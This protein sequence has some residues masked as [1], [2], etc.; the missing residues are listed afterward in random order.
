MVADVEWEP[1]LPCDASHVPVARRF[2][3][4]LFTFGVLVILSP[5]SL[6][7]N[8][9][10]TH[11]HDNGRTGRSAE[12]LRFP[13]RLHWRA[14]LPTPEPAWPPPARQDY[15][16]RKTSLRPRVVHDRA[17]HIV[18]GAGKLV[19]GSSA[20]DCVRAFD[21]R[22]GK[23]VWT[24]WAEAPVR[25]AP[26]IWLPDDT[27]E[28]KVVFGADDGCVYGVDLSSGTL[29]WKTR[30]EEVGSRRIP[31]NGRIISQRPIR[32]GVMINREG[33][34]FFVAGIF[35]LQGAYFFSI[36]VRNGAILDRAPIDKSV[37]GYL[38]QRGES[39]FA[40]TGRDLQ[41]AT[42]RG[43]AGK[44][45]DE[46]HDE[47]AFAVI[48]DAARKYSGR[49]DQV[50]AV[51]GDSAVWQAEVQGR[52]YDLAI[53]NGL[54][55]A[56]TDLGWIYAFGAAESGRAS[57]NLI[58]LEHAPSDR[59]SDRTKD[60]SDRDYVLFVEPQSEEEI[61]RLCSWAR[62]SRFRTVVTVSSDE[63]ASL[64]RHH[65]EAKNLFAAIHVNRSS[66]SLPYG[67]KSFH[68]VFGGKKQQVRKLLNPHGGRADCVDGTVLA[69]AASNDDWSHPYGNA[70]NTASSTTRIG[71]GDLR[72][73]WFGGPGPQ[74]MVDR[75]MRTMPPLASGGMM[76]LPGLNQ[77]IAVD[78]YTGVVR[79][80]QYIPD[81]TRIGI[82]KDCGW[83]VSKEDA[84]LV[85]TGNALTEYRSD[86]QAPDRVASRTVHTMPFENR[87]WGYLAFLDNRIVG[88]SVLPGSSRKTVNRDAILEGAYTDDRPIVC[89]DA[90]FSTAESAAPWEYTSRG[91][92]LNPTLAVNP[93]VVV[94]AENACP[95][96][97]SAGGRLTLVEFL[98]HQPQLV[99]LS[100]ET[101]KML[102][103]VDLPA[104]PDAQNAFVV[105]DQDHV[106][107]VN[108]RNAQTV[109]YDV[110]VY[111]ALDGN[112]LWKTTQDNRNKVG[113]DHGEQDKHPVLVGNRLI[114]EPLCYDIR[115]GDKLANIH[116][117]QRGY[118]CGTISASA[119]ALF[120]RS[121]NPAKY[122]LGTQK[123]ER[124]TAVTRP[125]CWIN[126][127]PASG[128]LLIPEGSSGCTCNFAVQTSMAL[129]PA[130]P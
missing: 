13:L 118:G 31:G 30:P 44:Q 125:G 8:D 60:S 20:D 50:V 74:N 113:G 100:L 28:A 64:L 80:K 40:P 68:R 89:S 63:H 52:V 18:I 7:A 86:A 59:A 29:A 12:T 71:D 90:V 79:W 112:L 94:F 4:L 43:A 114:V 56:S 22:T 32:S 107:L 87:E 110:R 27:E 65:L 101:G 91:A 26:S 84:L 6:L 67:G 104:I 127:I 108:S 102:W 123:L 122:S 77:V 17:N 3:R 88:S 39:V 99:A 93:R 46:L 62:N 15:W 76:Y 66:E 35:P 119:D 98:R 116:L 115:T 106:A 75:H 69:T 16:H 130:Q 117:G 97:K 21:Q 24:V 41:G 72:L 105:C 37:Q 82:L 128:M 23:L 48:A 124:V 111:A 45:P 96:L 103:R 120:F 51:E 1:L 85:A 34:G 11:L 129:A 126:M 36:D 25:L 10:P 33:T 9:W 70:G 49:Q 38:Q 5:L 14:K 2:M 83:M 81:S 95:D 53:S 47:D 73:Q 121:G 58:R 57:P 54:L 92:I 42:L 55:F 109:H 78:A 61:E 19:V